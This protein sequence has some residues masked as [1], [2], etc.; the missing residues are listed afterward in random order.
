VL[1]A[2]GL[3]AFVNDEIVANATTLKPATDAK[4]KKEAET[5]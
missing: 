1:K 2:T 4:L 5:T 3:G